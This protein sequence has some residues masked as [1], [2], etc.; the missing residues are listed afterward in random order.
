VVRAAERAGSAILQ[1][2][3]RAAMV[4]GASEWGPG[5]DREREN[6]PDETNVVP[7][8]KVAT[9]AGVDQSR[10][11]IEASSA[12]GAPSFFVRDETK[13]RNA[14]ARAFRFRL[15]PRRRA[16]QTNARAVTRTPARRIARP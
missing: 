3:V 5:R 4:P 9:Q 2:W 16:R 8:P 14:S 12:R 11:G 7:H 15:F 6:P 13:N 1:V 10:R